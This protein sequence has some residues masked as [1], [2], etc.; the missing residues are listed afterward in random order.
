MCGPNTALAACKRRHA[1]V[2]TMQQLANSTASVVLVVAYVPK[3]LQLMHRCATAQAALVYLQ[4]LSAVSH[5]S[6]SQWSVQVQ[7]DVL[8]PPEVLHRLAIGPWGRIC[9]GTA[10]G[11]VM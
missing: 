5:P 3:T 8:P 6:R 9:R 1:V 7:L 4:A 2:N 10:I 11:C